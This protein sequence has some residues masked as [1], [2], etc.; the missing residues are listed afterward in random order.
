MAIETTAL[1]GEKLG[2]KQQPANER[3]AK[4]DLHLGSILRGLLDIFWPEQNGFNCFLLNARIKGQHKIYQFNF[5][6]HQ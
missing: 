3:S 6:S 2:V 5:L 4:F 1:S